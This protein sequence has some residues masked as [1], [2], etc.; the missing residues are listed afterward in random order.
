MSLDLVPDGK[1]HQK[2]SENSKYL[3][4]ITIAAVAV[5]CYVITNGKGAGSRVDLSIRCVIAM[6]NPCMACH[7]PSEV[8]NIMKLFAGAG[9]FLGADEDGIMQSFHNRKR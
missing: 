9:N 8:K 4:N 5:R 2:H 1:C 6:I 3:L 7:V